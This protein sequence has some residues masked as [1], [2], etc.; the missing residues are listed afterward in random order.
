MAVKNR[1]LEK[2]RQGIPSVGTITHL[3][4]TSAVECLGVTGLDYVLIDMEHAPVEIGEAQAYISAADAAGITP[5]VRIAEISRGAILKS[6]D[7]GAKGVIVPGVETVEQ[8]K[9]LIAYAKFKPLGDR[10]Y[11]M[12]RDGKWG[13]G[14]DYADGMTGYMT[15]C[16]RDTLLLP[17]CETLGCLEHIEEITAIDGVDGILIGPFDLSIAM[18]LDGQFTHPEFKKAVERI[19]KACKDNGKLAMIFTGKADD[20]MPRVKEGF[21]SVLYGLDI[22][23]VID[24]YKA[25]MDHFHQNN[26]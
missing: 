14:E 25:I 23:T 18:G 6:L 20:I 7:A 26:D 15:A 9:D 8:V 3:R 22:L 19:L 12:T 17:Q 21:D 5:I 16:N 24:H 1:I 13:Y 4:S 10:G 11:C 2:Y